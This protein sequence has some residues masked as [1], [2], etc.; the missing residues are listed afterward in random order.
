MSEFSSDVVRNTSDFAA[1]YLNNVFGA[2]DTL[3]LTTKIKD[4]LYGS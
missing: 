2:A 4:L 1:K 3:E